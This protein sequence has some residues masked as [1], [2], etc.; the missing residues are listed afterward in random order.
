M[1]TR[2]VG[3]LRSRMASY[4]R[5]VSRA[6]QIVKDGLEVCPTAFVACSF[7]KDS[8][9]I[10]DIVRKI[11]P[12]I[13]ARF[14]RW[15]ESSLLY[16]FDRVI[17]EWESLGVKITQI[18]LERATLDDKVSD[19]WEKMAQIAPAGGSFVGLRAQE[20]KGRRI[21]LAKSGVIYQNIKGFWRI[22][23]LAWMQTEDIA[24]YIY[25]HNLPTLSVYDEEGFQERTASRVPRNDYLIRQE[26]LNK[27]AMRDPVAFAR[28]KAIYPEVS[29]YV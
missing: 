20:S 10:L 6:E 12:D 1:I 8:A 25:E 13:E 26:M 16:D 5:A 9:V 2:D 22:C 29:E 17:S 19:R 14:V 27:L 21:T 24:A 7:G 28:L 3:R 18:H 23:P 15:S 11:K 4:K